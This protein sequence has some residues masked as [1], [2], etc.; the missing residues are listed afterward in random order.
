MPSFDVVSELNLQEVDNAVNQAKK[1]IVTRY[2]FKGSKSDLLLDKD[3]I[4]LTS[5]DDYK[6]TALI[7]ILQSKAVKRGVSLKAF[8]LGKIER[9]A[10]T[11]VK[12]LVKLIQGIE[13]EKAR[14]LVKMVKGLNLKVQAAIEGEKLRIS[15]KSRDDLQTVIQF[16]RS[17][18]FPIPLQFMN[19][20]D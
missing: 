14:E 9:G 5:D 12:C 2:D 13:T 19:F 11:T 10:G 8:D 15:G 4:H 6:M 7:D 17:K 20:R 18:D 16:L 1:E 3:G